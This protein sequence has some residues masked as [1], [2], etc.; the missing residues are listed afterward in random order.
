MLVE[1]RLLRRGALVDHVEV[2]RQLPLARNHRPVPRLR[3]HVGERDVGRVEVHELPVVPVVVQSRHQLDPG[4]R[5][6]RLRVPVLEPHALRGDPVEFGRFVRRPAVG[7]QRLDAEIVGEDDDDVGL[8]G[9]L[10]RRRAGGEQEHGYLDDQHG[11]SRR[12]GVHRRQVT[13]RRKPRG[14]R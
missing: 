11:P 3:Q 10:G 8:E 6:Q 5:A 12:L 1:A 14:S 7:A 2:V 13:S 9:W 4:R